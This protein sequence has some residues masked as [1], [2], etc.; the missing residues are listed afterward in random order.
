LTTSQNY[1]I[2]DIVSKK[3]GENVEIKD[4]TKEIEMKLSEIRDYK[5]VK[6]NDLIQKSRF[7]LSLQEQKIILYMIS[8]IKPDDEIFMEQEFK[9]IEFCRVC[10]IETNSGKNYKNVKDAIKALADKSVWVTL[11]TGSETLVRWINK[12]WINRKSGVIKIRLDDDMKPYL[13]QL[14][15][16]FTS[17][18]LLYTLAMKSQYSVRLYELLKSYEWRHRQTFQIE[19]LKRILSAENYTRFPDFKR[20]VLDISMREI[21]DLSDLTVTYEIVKEGRRYAKLDFSIKLKKDLDERMRTW[22]K[23]EEV[24]NPAQMSLFE[25]VHGEKP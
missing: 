11:E 1:N 9:I 22:A 19:E 3:G 15:E 4:Q 14:Q 6:S 17:Y 18:E 13:L 23:I 25:R 16:R 7:Q 8:K 20:Y 21:N 12:A 5:V 24:I 10:G 2:L